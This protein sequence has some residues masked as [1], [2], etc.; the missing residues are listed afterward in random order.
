[1]AGK[2]VKRA[3]GLSALLVSVAAALAVPALALAQAPPGEGGAVVEPGQ[4]GEAGGGGLAATGFDVWQ[5]ALAGV[6]CIALA[7]ALLKSRRA[8]GSHVA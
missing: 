8:R 4:G 3:R 7:L 6:L 5:L 1:M 2:G